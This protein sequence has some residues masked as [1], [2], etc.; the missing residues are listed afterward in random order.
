[1]PKIVFTQSYEKRARNFFKRQ[2]G[3]INQYEK[4]LAILQ[5]NP[6]HPA[7]RLHK[8]KGKLADLYSIAINM[9]YRISLEFT[10]KEDRIVLI[11]IGKHDE[12]Y[13]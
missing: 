9:Q 8:L 12:I 1:M 2:Q 7:L 10:V 13:K 11:D 3:L 4:T 6:H 5:A